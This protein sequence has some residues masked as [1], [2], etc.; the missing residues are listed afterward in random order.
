[1]IKAHAYGFVLLCVCTNILEFIAM[2]I[3]YNHMQL[4]LANCQGVAGGKNAYLTH[5]IRNKYNERMCLLAGQH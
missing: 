5:H 4:C 1:M 3:Q 2:T